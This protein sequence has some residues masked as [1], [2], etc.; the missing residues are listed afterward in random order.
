MTVNPFHR[1]D[2]GRADKQILFFILEH[3]S[4]E[5]NIGAS[6]VR[7]DVI[8]KSR[9]RSWKVKRFERGHDDRAVDP[10]KVSG[11]WSGIGF[12]YGTEIQPLAD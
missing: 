4:E 3:D 10:L 2:F 5:R 12:I 1:T 9:A 11:I 6:R 8:H 7:S